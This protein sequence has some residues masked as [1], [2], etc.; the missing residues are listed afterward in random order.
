VLQRFQLCLAPKARIDRKYQ[1]TIAPK[2]G[3]PMILRPRGEV[4]RPVV[5]RGTIHDTVDLTGSA[6]SS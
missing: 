5:P 1:V 3:M 6:I 2:Y 4:L